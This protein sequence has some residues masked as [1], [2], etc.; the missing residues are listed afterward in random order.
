MA[1]KDK[2]KPVEAEVQEQQIPAEE[3]Q[4]A[5][6]TAQ[7]GEFGEDKW[8]EALELAVK[9]RDEYLNMAQRTQADFDNFRR[10]NNNTRADA[11]SDGAREV[12]AALLP[13]VDNLDRALDAAQQSGDGQGL[14]EGVEMIS[15]QLYEILGKLG[16]EEIPALG[17]PFDPELHNAV[18]RGPGENPGEIIEVFQ[19]GY[20]VKD[21][22]VRYAMVKVAADE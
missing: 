2:K 13:V 3:N 7:T 6:E 1:K 19:K 20:R 16:M 17:E 4:P 14:R 5:E 21:K 12:I 18:M 11:Y 8:R 15:R 22:I 9:Q 10:R